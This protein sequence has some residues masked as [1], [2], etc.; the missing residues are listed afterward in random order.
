MPH[1][2]PNTLAAEISTLLS[3]RF[4]LHIRQNLHRESRTEQS[5]GQCTEQ[6]RGLG[7]QRYSRRREPERDGEGQSDNRLER[8]LREELGEKRL[9]PESRLLLH[10]LVSRIVLA[11]GDA[12]RRDAVEQ[13]QPPRSHAAEQHLLRP[14]K[15]IPR[16]VERDIAVVHDASDGAPPGVD[17]LGG[18]PEPVL[19]LNTTRSARGNI[20]GDGETRVQ[21][22]GGQNRG[23]QNPNVP[24][25][26][27]EGGTPEW[28]VHPVL[29]HGRYV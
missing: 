18:R 13:P 19:D 7:F 15:G 21:S 10:L 4:E 29:D 24:W 17:D 25:G 12:P 6:A 27:W 5:D 1:N 9:V 11:P 23:S 8:S 28:V 22:E 26:Q 2:T 16:N 3:M 14:R 20:C